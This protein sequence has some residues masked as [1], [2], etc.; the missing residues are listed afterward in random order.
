MRFYQLYQSLLAYH[1][2]TIDHTILTRCTFPESRKSHDKFRDLV[3]TANLT[4][5]NRL[6]RQSLKSP[7][8][9]IRYFQQQDSNW[10]ASSR[11]NC[12]AAGQSSAERASDKDSLLRIDLQKLSLKDVSACKFPHVCKSSYTVHSVTFGPNTSRTYLARII[13]QII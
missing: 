2:V 9:I 1:V 5:I 3:T 11:Q 12:Y 4:V 10:E 6:S 13:S 8:S 7:Y